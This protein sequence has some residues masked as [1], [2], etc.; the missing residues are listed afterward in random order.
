[1]HLKS[2]AHANS[3]PTPVYLRQARPQT[4]AFRFVILLVL[5]QQGAY[6]RGKYVD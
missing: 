4:A 1:M 3:P 6:H 2:V 5:F